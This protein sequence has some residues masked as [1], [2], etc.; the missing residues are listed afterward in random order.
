MLQ[1][2]K[3]S[4]CE[5]WLDEVQFLAHVI[6]IQSIEEDPAKIETM[7][8]WEIPQIVIEVQ[9]FLGLT[10]YYRRFVEGFSKIVSPLT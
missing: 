3:L 4:K 8:K 9:S 7:V 1:Y 5:F 10:S 6:S 2:E